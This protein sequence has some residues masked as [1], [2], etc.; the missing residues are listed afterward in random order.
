MCALRSGADMRGG[1]GIFEAGGVGPRACVRA[2]VCIAF[3]G[4]SVKGGGGGDIKTSDSIK[5]MALLYDHRG[6]SRDTLL[7]FILYMENR[8]VCLQFLCIEK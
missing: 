4:G 3:R 1:E 7:E 5:Q 8:S 2:C 6:T